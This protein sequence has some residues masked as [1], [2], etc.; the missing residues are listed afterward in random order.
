MKQQLN[1]EEI[2]KTALKLE[3]KAINKENIPLKLNKSGAIQL[4]KISTILTAVAAVFIFGWIL[5]QPRIEQRKIAQLQA[6]VEQS[7]ISSE[8]I[9]SEGALKPV[10][11]FNSSIQSLSKSNETI[12]NFNSKMKK[13]NKSNT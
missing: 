4:P 2:Y 3:Q 10:V 1:P 11:R 7:A 5:I 8:L 12:Q 13:F 9:N 6:K